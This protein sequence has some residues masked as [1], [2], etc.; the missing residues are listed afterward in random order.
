MHCTVLKDGL[1]HSCSFQAEY[2]SDLPHFDFDSDM[3]EWT[4]ARAF[5]KEDWSREYFDRI[6]KYVSLRKGL[7][8]ILLFLY[9]ILKH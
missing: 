3:N 1:S 4:V 5:A 6:R 7:P 8:N 2:T 9:F